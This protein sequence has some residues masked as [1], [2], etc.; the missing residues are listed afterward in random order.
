[1]ARKKREDA[2]RTQAHIVCSIWNTH[3]ESFG[4]YHP[5]GWW[6]VSQ[7]DLA[8][9]LQIGRATAQR[10]LRELIKKKLISCK[11]FSGEQTVTVT[12]SKRRETRGIAAD[13]YQ[14]SK[15]QLLMMA[16]ELHIHKTGMIMYQDP[17]GHIHLGY[18]QTVQ[19][20]IDNGTVRP[21]PE[22]PTFAHTDLYLYFSHEIE[23]YSKERREYLPFD[24][25]ANEFLK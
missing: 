23:L 16:I 3:I 6:E 19:E 20:F 5:D 25:V 10:V 13:S 7:T 8:D 15:N 17:S 18:Q 21:H 14:V 12:G 4:G 11:S 24:I 22:L 2:L 9:Q 1:M